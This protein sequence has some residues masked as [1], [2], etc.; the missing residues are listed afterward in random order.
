MSRHDASRFG[1]IGLVFGGTSAEREVSLKSGAAAAAALNA[2][3]IEYQVFDGAKAVIEAAHGRSIDTV[4]N[5]LHGRGGEDGCLQGALAIYDIDVTGSDL[6][7][8]ALSMNKLQTKRIWRACGLPTPDW[9]VATSTADAERII[10]ELALPVFVKP[11][12]EGSSVGMSRVS[13]RQAL[14]PALEQAL[15]HDS[16]VLVERLVQGPEYTASILQ[17][18]SLPLIRITTPSGFYDYNAKYQS[19]QTRYAC[20]CG[21]DV[22]REIELQE[23]ARQAFQL[24][25]CS[26]WGRVDFM[27]DEDAAPWLLEANTVPGM[28]DHSLV[29]MAAAA[30]GLDFQ[31]LV[32][33]I[34]ETACSHS[35]EQPLFN[36]QPKG[37]QSWDD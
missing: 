7:S 30:A 29:P 6:L 3:G 31:E 32:W 4:L 14:R 21:L 17:Q 12:R 25:G 22:G 36:R 11:A 34:L 10:A 28:T 2:M 18:Q 16:I 23:L 37:S 19:T 24:L 26:G 35:A 5:L 33:R 13:T 27:L 15:L 9:R 8:S 20:P 1:N